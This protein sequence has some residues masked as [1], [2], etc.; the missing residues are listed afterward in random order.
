MQPILQ[1]QKKKLVV[2]L[3]LLCVRDV[4][5][6]DFSYILEEKGEQTFQVVRKRGIAAW[7]S[8]PYQG[9]LN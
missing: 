2:H 7:K 6:R 1:N 3:R 5:I 4:K 9:Q 8:R